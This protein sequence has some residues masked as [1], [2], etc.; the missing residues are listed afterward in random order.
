MTDSAKGDFRRRLMLAVFRIQIEMNA[1]RQ[2]EYGS[3]FF[4]SARY[5][6]TAYHCL[7]KAVILRTQTDIEATYVDASGTLREIVFE[8]VPHASSEAHDVAVLKV[9]RKP[10]RVVPSYLQPALLSVNTALAIA[11]DYWAK[12]RFA[13]YGFPVDLEGTA[14]RYV[15]GQ[16]SP[17]QS[18]TEVA[19]TD[20]STGRFTFRSWRFRCLAQNAHN[21]PGFSGSP[22]Y[23]IGL[24]CV[25]GV[26]TNYEEAPVSRGREEKHLVFGTPLCRLQEVWPQFAK[27]CGAILL[28]PA[29]PPPD[30][31]RELRLSGYRQWLKKQCEHSLDLLALQ[32]EEGL[33]VRLNAVTL[34]HVY[35]PLVTLRPAE[36]EEAG[37][38]TR[39][40]AGGPERFQL[41]LDLFN[42][43]SLYVPGAPGSGK[44]TF[45]RW[46]TWLT[47]EGT[48]PR[49]SV[50]SLEN[51]RETFPE[52]LRNRMPL[53]IR[54]REFWEYIALQPGV[55]EMSAH[56]FEQA[57]QEWFSTRPGGLTWSDA[58]IH[59]RAGR[60]LLLF[61]GI[62]EAPITYEKDNR[63]NEPREMLLSGLAAV[64]PG[65]RDLG[66]H[67]LVTSRP[68]GL[69]RHHV[70][71]LDLREARIEGL[72][73]ELQDLLV[74]RWF[75]VLSKDESEACATA[76]EMLAQVRSRDM[77][78]LAANP[79]LL[80]AISVMFR[81]A[82]RLPQHKY[83][84]Y[85]QMV[86]HVLCNRFASGTADATKQRARL[87]VIA[88]GMHT[89]SGLG[90]AWT[91][92]RAEVGNEDVDEILRSYVAGSHARDVENTEPAQ[93]RETLLSHSGLLLPRQR[94]RA[95]FLHFS[96]Q[97]FLAAERLFN[98]ERLR[99][100][101]IF[102][103]RGAFAEWR[104]TLG[105]VFGK[106]LATSA[107]AVDV[108]VEPFLTSLIGEAA[109]RDQDLNL[110]VVTADCLEIFLAAGYHVR[111]AAEEQFRRLCLAAIERETPLFQR[112]ELGLALG[113]LGD[114]RVVVDLRNPEQT[115]RLSRRAAV[116][117][118]PGVYLFDA[119][120]K[121]IDLG[122]PL[123]M[124][125]YAVTNSQFAVFVKDG[126]YHNRSERYW[127]N[128]G[129]Q[130][131][132]EF[133]PRAPL[134]WRDPRWN[135]PNQPVVGVSFWEADA[136]CR[137][138]GGRLP[139]EAEWEAA[140]RG[141]RGLVY[142]WGDKWQD[143]IC[144]SSAARV[145]R[146]S[147]AGL[148]PSSRSR[149]FALEDMAGNV[150]E[151]TS[152]VYPAG[153]EHRML[154][155]GSWDIYGWVCRAASRV[156]DRPG[157]R[158]RNVGFRVVWDG[159][160]TSK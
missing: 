75:N 49:H 125:R 23:D 144:N 56:Q 94:E 142:P 86:N 129:L 113:T 5:A 119:E 7:P 79:M 84:L 26:Q 35:V 40:L 137:W 28:D 157:V 108:G 10:R 122:T 151:W 72:S 126:G 156:Y 120:T 82:K 130:W 3:G 52:S 61:D 143:G 45:C 105:F 24:G 6:L 43:E 22:I 159:A 70:R 102:A 95:G 65:W 132:T 41:L 44:S 55:R 15:E 29:F 36:A 63:A 153:D 81:N 127:S 131:L 88:F 147:P 9:K 8:W 50:G 17:R 60:M 150:W 158:D 160:S 33:A 21:L 134:Y 30:R 25:V 32:P 118:P 114:P 69:S 128:E 133:Q 76:Q 2:W 99:L 89:G 12:Q 116:D 90:A 141:P 92:P 37:V 27:R 20:P 109:R 58:D 112:H 13:M 155:G 80:T 145:G 91:A 85:S 97:E 96:V 16:F 1:S 135:R 115:D 34:N 78:G 83:E 64:V 42:S 19:L 62:D 87:S 138:C 121:K 51:Y 68:N 101:D 11:G 47:C 106:L 98:I 124:S 154:R 136:F 38:V 100:L 59:L 73:P 74:H 139:T 53:L 48:M 14:D 54:V 18:I 140:A 71:A 4:V 117:V 110:Q 39:R 66:N 148:F 123:R 111:E 77:E 107:D 57:V 67:V 152:D 103:E 46:V 149:E 104:N 31:D 93:A 146:T